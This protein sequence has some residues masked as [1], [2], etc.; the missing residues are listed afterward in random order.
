MKISIKFLAM[1]SLT[2]MAALI[3]MGCS[4]SGDDG[5]GKAATEIEPLD[6]VLLGPFSEQRPKVRISRKYTCHG[7]NV[8]PPLTWSGGPSETIS[9][10]LIATDIDYDNYTHWVIYNIPGNVM[11]LAEGIPTSTVELPDGTIQ[12]INDYKRIGWEGPC[13]IQTVLQLYPDLDGGKHRAT[14][15]KTG[16]HKYQ[17]TLYALDNN[18]D[19]PSGKTMSELLDAMEGHVLAEAKR[20]GKFGLPPLTQHQIDQGKKT[21]SG[22]GKDGESTTS[23]RA[24]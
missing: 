6:F 13:P 1:F 7:E 21:Q 17:F 20:V 18:F 12:G 2:V 9:Y 4:S 14:L 3:A 23:T 22:A 8:S 24:N 5:V 16:P 11:E 10:A 15:Q 19:L